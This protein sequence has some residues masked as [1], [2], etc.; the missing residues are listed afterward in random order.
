M[1]LRMQGTAGELSSLFSR[2]QATERVTASVEMN[3]HVPFAPAEVV[4][5]KRTMSAKARRAISLAQKARW[6]KRSK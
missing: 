3:G 4:N 5:K 1:Q 6:A 2:I